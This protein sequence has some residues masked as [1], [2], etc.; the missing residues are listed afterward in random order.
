[1][2]LLVVGYGLVMGPWFW[3]N[4]QVAGTPLPVSGSQTIW[5]AGYD[6][7]FSYQQELSARTFFEQGLGPILRGRWW[8]L[9]ANLQTVLA[10]WGLIFA[11]PLAVIGGWQLRRQPLVQLAGL[12]GLL[13]FL[14]MSL[15]FAFPGAR[16]GLF[17][18]GTALLPF[19]YGLAAA[20]LDR[21]VDWMA[22]RRRRWKAAPA[23]RIFSLGMIV[24]AAALS[25]FIYYQRVLKNN[26]WNTADGLYPAIAGWVAEQDPTATVMIG[27][28]PAY[29][30]HGG[31]LSV[32]IPNE[33]LATTLRVAA[34]YQVD[35]LVLDHNHPAPL[36]ELYQA[37][38]AEPALA[39]V[40][41][42]GRGTQQEIYIFRVE[43][44]RAGEQD[45]K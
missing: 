19:I 21:G 43:Q 22:A 11:A 10:V 5:L 37:P 42:F 28:P 4:W 40:Q 39:L 8:A 17:H 7:L 15:I 33:D 23:K 1:M 30:Y 27:N 29:R 25:S 20:G 24:M 6:D 36:A 16:G 38:A 2:G 44:E 41:T 35:Y 12:Y 3:R 32:V 31:G 9:T 13:L 14:V 45:D 18:S 26:S 34:A